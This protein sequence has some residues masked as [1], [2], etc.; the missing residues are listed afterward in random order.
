MVATALSSDPS[1]ICRPQGSRSKQKTLLV[2]ASDLTPEQVL[3]KL[4]SQVDTANK[5]GNLNS[6]KPG[7]LNSD[8][9]GNLN[10]DKPGNLNSD[11]P[12]NLNSDKP[13]NLN[14]DKRG[15]LN[16][17][18]RVAGALELDGVVP[19]HQAL[20][21]RLLQLPLGICALQGGHV[22][23]V[24]AHGTGGGEAKDTAKQV[25][26][27]PTHFWRIGKVELEEVNPHLRGA[28]MEN[29]LG[30][31]TPSSPDQDLNLDLPILSSR[32]QHDKRVSQLRHR[33]GSHVN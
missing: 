33:G 20:F 29:H 3:Q 16:F 6:D 27:I 9:R 18:K 13:G 8:K 23:Q 17:D 21:V 11:K 32:A 24:A 1:D 25:R 12:G 28:R 7:N 22:L 14:S 19:L 26:I 30:K 10:S 2:T 5:R 31:T 4:K 15:N